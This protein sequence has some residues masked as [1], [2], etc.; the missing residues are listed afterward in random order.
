VS[1]AGPRTATLGSVDVGRLAAV[2]LFALA[3]LVDAAHL[4]HVAAAQTSDAAG[5]ASV[6][7]SL[8]TVAFTVMVIVCYLRRG[9]ATATTTSVPAKLAAGVA[10]WTPFV[11]PL[12]VRTQSSLTPDLL[13]SVLVVAGLA[14]S[15]W[16]L[17]SL[18]TNLSIV[19]QARGLSS[20]GPYRLVRHPLYVGEVLAV[21][22]LAVRTAQPAMVVWFAVLV[23]LQ[24]YRASVEEQLLAEAL[25]GYAEYRS[26]TGRFVPRLRTA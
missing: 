13:A 9:P 25:P 26:L 3:L 10:T 24:W 15:L 14:W 7:A 8:L 22:G 5:V 4:A 6:V 11:L 12:F 23:L 21:L 20:T 16:A 1:V 19:A 2:P 18:G 17:A